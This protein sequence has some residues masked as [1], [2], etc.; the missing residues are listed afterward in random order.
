MVKRFLVGAVVSFAL[1]GLLG[2]PAALAHE[3]GMPPKPGP[4]HAKLGFF[5]GTWAS[6]GMMNESPFG[7]GGKMTSTDKCE[8]FDK[9]FAVVCNYEGTGP[10]GVMKG[11][12]IISYSPMEKIYTYYGLGNDG[13]AMTTVPR[14]T[15]EGGTWTFL[16][17]TKMGDQTMKTR[18]VIKELSPTSY[19]WQME[20]E[21]QGGV[22]STILKGKSTKK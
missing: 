20:S 17:E 4:E 3:G 12:G 8:W 6:E 5:V 13:M 7:P 22:W 9:K 2:L 16:D 18:Y 11:I 21:G 19:T 1:A 10:A 15:L 14:G